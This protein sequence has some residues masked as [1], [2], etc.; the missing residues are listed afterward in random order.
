MCP[1]TRT[2]LFPPS[3]RRRPRPWRRSLFVLFRL[4]SAPVMRV[5]VIPRDTLLPRLITLRIL[6]KSSKMNTLSG[7]ASSA[8][9]MARQFQFHLPTHILQFHHSHTTVILGMSQSPASPSRTQVWTLPGSCGILYLA[10][11]P[12]GDIQS[13]SRSD[14]SPW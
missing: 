6:L 14:S 9:A 1:S 12:M 8:I 3:R 7:A 5:Q 4:G 13:Q 10:R 11:C 2:C